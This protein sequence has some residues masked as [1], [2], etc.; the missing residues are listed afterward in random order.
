MKSDQTVKVIEKE[1]QTLQGPSN[2]LPRY[3]PPS[4]GLLSLLPTS[5][6]PYAELMRLDR[7]A[8]FYAFYVP[9]LI[10]LSYGA[11][12]ASPTPSLKHLLTHGILFLIGSTILRGAACTWNDNIDQDL[13]R[14][15]ARCCRRPIARGAVTA[16]QGHLFTAVL[17]L[18]GIPIF[19]ALP[20]ECAY[21]A[22]P[23]TLLFALYPFAK[24]VTNYPQVLL[25][26]P[27]A[28]AVLMCCAALGVD[29][30]GAE[31]IVPTLSLFM[32]NILW[33]IIYDTIYA[34]QDLKDDVRA[35]VKSMAVRFA[36][37]TK[38]L[39]S[40]LAVVQVLLLVVA[41]WQAGFGL[42]YFVVTC[43]CTTIALAMKITSVNLDQPA[44]CAWWFYHGFWFVGGSV[45]MGLFGE[46]MDRYRHLELR[47]LGPKSSNM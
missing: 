2:T 39:V 14:R 25:G 43:G 5:W 33:T 17:T 44:S 23:V 6:I 36:D 3:S 35:G 11:C 13:D 7:P 31:F 19:L 10:G 37:S 12:L 22:I 47:V 34:H 30:F 38:P 24:R 8:G 28:W 26:F 16:F 18:A 41:G 20:I 27:F 45:V 21:H 46:Y 40:F 15:V 42:V 29:P 4:Q 9:Y 32:A 1:N